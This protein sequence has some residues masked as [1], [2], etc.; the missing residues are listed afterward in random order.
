MKKTYAFVTAISGALLLFLS[1]CSLDPD[2]KL[3]SAIEQYNEKQPKSLQALER[4]FINT[5]AI[6]SVEGA[7]LQSS[8]TFLYRIQ[9]NS[10]DVAYPSKN[11]YTL[12]DGDAIKCIDST[13]D[14]T[15]ISDGQQFC[16]FDGDGD[17]RNDE[18]IGDKKNQVKA[19]LVDSDT[20]IYYKNFKLFRYSIVHNSSEQIL[21]ETFPPPYKNYYLAQLTKR[22][23]L[24]SIV[25]GIAGSHYLNLV[26]LSTG[27]VMVK[28]FVMSS[29]RHHIGIDTIRYI[30]G[31]SGN[32]ELMQYTIDS[33][34]KKSV[35]KLA[36]IVDIELTDQGYLLETKT[37]LWTAAYGK[38]R[39]RI[40]FSYEL[41]GRYKGRIILKYMN[42]YYFID[43]KKMFSVLKKL[44]EK[45]PDLFTGQK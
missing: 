22:D 2:R 30:A 13:G 10:V 19:L 25:T 26:N 21:K 45:T 9:D 38:D 4:E 35:A 7:N 41:A 29:S 39:I 15:V 44:T 12:T 18:T 8:G 3:N 40:P 5:I 28:N 43:M 36:D 27:A 32:W 16:I 42:A 11:S 14:F 1:S 34:G 37:G 24:L 6:Y 23:N 31:N 17:H 33:K 20:I